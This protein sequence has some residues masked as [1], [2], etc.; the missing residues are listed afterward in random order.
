MSGLA[1][2]TQEALRAELDRSDPGH[3]HDVVCQP[4]PMFHMAGASTRC[5]V[6]TDGAAAVRWTALTVPGT[7]P[8]GGQVVEFTHGE[9]KDLPPF[10]PR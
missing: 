10:P 8:E 9:R 4:V 5:D 7:A 6:T 3:I 1:W 2:Q